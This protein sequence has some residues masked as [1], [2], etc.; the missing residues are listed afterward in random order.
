MMFSLQWKEFNRGKAVG[1]KLVAKILKWFGIIYFAFMAFMMGIIASAY[2]GPLAEFPLEDGTTASFL[3]VNKQ[4]IYVFVYLI[5]MRYF[6]QSLPVL[7]IKALL[8]TPL[9][10]IKIVRFSLLKTVLTY[11]NIL[12]L[13]FLIPFSFLLASTGDYDIVGLIFWNINIIGLIY[14]TNF[15]NFLL[16]NKDKLLYG[17]GGIL[18]LIKILEYYSIVDFT[19]Y[20]EQ[21]FYLF[22]SQPYAVAFTW[23][24]VFWLYN[25]VNKYLLQGLYI[26]T[27][28]QV[29]T[30]EAKMEDFSFLDR[31]GKTATFIKND[32]RL[33]K[34]SKRARTAVYM[35]IGMLF[36]GIIFVPSEE[37]LGS[38]FLFFGYLFS[39]GGFL[40]MFGSFVPSWDSQ[41]YP[42]MM[43][44]NIEYKEY[45]NSKWSLMI[46]GTVIS[47]VLASFIYSFFGVNA[48]YAVLAGAFYNIGVN[49]YLTLWAGAYTKSPIDLN[50]SA[51]AF[52]DKK[53]FNAKTML[54]GIPQMLLPVLV[55]Y[56]TSQYYDHFTGCLAVAV[57]GTLGILLK[58]IAFNLILKAYKTE[59]YSTLKAYKTN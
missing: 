14:V 57:L 19:E 30:K 27:G 35:G 5:V 3:Y 17:V 6:V 31:F 58:P 41:Y 22:Y 42:L 23:L 24:L 52:G 45:L 7:N 49:G 50:S 28:L 44:Q 8:L 4:L 47:T 9:L 32:L 11:F 39:T 15:F 43:T 1:G 16:N 21:F 53:A 12:P 46:I 10:K 54:V 33:L 18:A 56:F 51:N 26:D 2:G 59:K 38:G 20:S 48:V 40:F 37:I 55:Y 13:F 29:K 25:Y 34:R 36:Y